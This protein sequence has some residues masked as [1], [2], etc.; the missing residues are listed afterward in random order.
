MPK[1]KEGLLYGS[2]VG[3]RGTNDASFGKTVVPV[4]EESIG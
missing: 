3:E 2:S 4:P 1:V